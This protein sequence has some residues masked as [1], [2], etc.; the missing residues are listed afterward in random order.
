MHLALVVG[1]FVF[2]SPSNHTTYDEEHQHCQEY[3]IL[4]H[5]LRVKMEST[6]QAIF[7]QGKD[8]GMQFYLRKP[9][10]FRL[11]HFGRIMTG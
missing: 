3:T 2:N 5:S 7:L 9:A 4:S 6:I 11:E 1:A 10:H 8:G